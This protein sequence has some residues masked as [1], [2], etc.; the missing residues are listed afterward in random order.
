MTRKII[1]ID[2]DAFFAA[3][4]QR[5]FPEL[6]GKPV[7][8][9]GSPQGRGVVATA[10]YEARKFGIRSAMPCSKAYRLCPH[11]IFRSVRF[12]A[13]QEASKTIRE[14][15]KEVTDLVEPLSLDEAYLDVTDNHFKEPSATRLAQWIKNE[16][17][18]RACLTASAGVGPNKFIAKVASDLHKP[19]GLVVVAPE[20]IPEFVR[21]LKVERLW[22]V[23]EATSRKLHQYGLYTAEDIQKMPESF[24]IERFGKSGS[25]LYH[26]SFG[27]DDRRI[28]P[29]REA[30][31]RGSEE[32]FPRDVTDIQHLEEILWE[33]AQEISD[34]LK[35]KN[36]KGKTVTL[37]V[38]YSDFE[39]ITRGH[40]MKN[41]VY[42]ENSIFLQASQ[43]LSQKTEAGLRPIRLIGISVSR[44]GQEDQE[45]L[46]LKFDF[47]E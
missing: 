25:F 17:E 34:G 19:D 47:F 31:S 35:R 3:V 18:K 40:T 33:Q 46:Q 24:M 29:S 41:S 21:T 27:R 9:G 36:L 2:M 5:D 1:H 44:F 8:I 6:K 10:S 45:P 11:G 23:G 7:I 12:E 14:I 20:K 43:L 13:Y 28:K 42:D 37:K 15:F 16:I 39:T 30:K 26:L 32:T 4:E 22:G 38:R